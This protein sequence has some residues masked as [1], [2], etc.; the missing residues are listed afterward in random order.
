MWGGSIS[1]FNKLLILKI[2]IYIAL[3]YPHLQ[4]FHEH[5]NHYVIIK[6]DKLFH[7]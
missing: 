6:A 2:S 3:E 4:S 5:F 1:Q 7:F